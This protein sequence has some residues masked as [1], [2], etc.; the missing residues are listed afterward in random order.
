MERGGVRRGRERSG[1]EK[2]S[3]KGAVRPGAHDVKV[4]VR[5]MTAEVG[6]KR[7]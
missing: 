2:S 3:E 7:G 5:N 4:G 6:P 1:G